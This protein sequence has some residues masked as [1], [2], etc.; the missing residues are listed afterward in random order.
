M[1]GW[2]A[3]VLIAATSVAPPPPP[4]PPTP[5]QVMAIPADAKA[6]LRER[7]TSTTNSPEKRLQRL[8]ELVFEPSGMGLQYDTEATLTVAET[9]QQRRANCLSFT[10]M[11]V[12]LAREVGLDADMQEVGQVV[13]WYQEQ[14]LIFN[15]GHVNVGM[16]M[17]GRQATLDLDSN[18]LYDRRGPRVI[19][20][21][22][23]LAH[24][25]NN[26]GA[27][28]L[29]VRDHAAARRYFEM[30]LQMDPRFVP[31][32]SNLGVL[33]ARLDDLPAASRDFDIALSINRDHAPSLHNA[34]NLYQRMGDSRRAAQLHKRL[35]R[36]RSRDPF[37]QFLLGVNAE[38]VGDYTGAV[39]HYR[40][41][42]RLHGTAHQFHFGL[43]RAY[44]LTGNNR[45]AE[46]EMTKA[47]A[48]GGNDRMRA[49]YQS[50]LDAI[51]R[52]SAQH[53]AH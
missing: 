13:T 31:A 9:W 30:A 28:Q 25:Y 47:R 33:D 49:I 4:V 41:A 39:A 18:V 34:T 24:F 6:Q 51:R 19:S 2:N 40:D 14:G 7:V 50:K 15:A 42:V 27:E 38:R 23:A 37:Y 52:L 45:Q 43:A 44:F 48:L 32:W 8:V 17:D 10:L 22:R 16:R 29:A 46:R 3:L 11:F 1:I 26:R 35:E 36:S 5:A 53:A 20:D 12:A 21:Q